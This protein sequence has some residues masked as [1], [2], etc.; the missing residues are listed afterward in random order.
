[1]TDGA[2]IGVAFRSAKAAFFRGAKG[3]NA[4]SQV[5]FATV[6]NGLLKPDREMGLPPGM[7]VRVTIEPCDDFAV[8]AEAACD[9]LDELCEELPIDSHGDRLTRD[10]L[11]G[12]N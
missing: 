2:G 1:L 10:R 5:I 7:K 8:Q 4:M 3:D 6:E 11:Y 12:R 9:A